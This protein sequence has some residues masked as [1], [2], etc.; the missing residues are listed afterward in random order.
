MQR[1]GEGRRVPAEVEK[2]AN[3]RDLVV[4]RFDAT[5]EFRPEDQ[6]VDF[7]QF[8]AIFDFVRRVTEIHRNGD[9]ARFQRAEVDREPFEAVH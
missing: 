7:G 1:L 8:E 6:V 4:N 3:A 5:D 2:A 9:R